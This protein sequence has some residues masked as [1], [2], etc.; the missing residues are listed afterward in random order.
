MKNKSLFIILTSILL[1]QLS[2]G[3]VKP[4]KFDQLDSL[5]K[6][7]RRTIVVFLHTSWC[8]YCGTMKN[9][10]FQNSEVLQLLNQNFYFVSLDIEEQRDIMF[11]GHTFKHK[12]TG[13]KTGVHELA[14]QLG[15]IN[16]ALAYPGISILNADFEI[17]HQQEGFVSSEVLLFMLKKLISK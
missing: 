4:V 2:F 9:T 15:T 7:E 1:C 14:R 11:R 5:Q 3:Q 16:G 10:T 13:N 17:I 8:K 12:P 6:K